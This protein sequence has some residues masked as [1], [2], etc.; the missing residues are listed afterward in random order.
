M[1]QPL[2]VTNR[3]AEY[4]TLREAVWFANLSSV[5]EHPVPWYCRRL[6]VLAKRGGYRLDGTTGGVE[7][8]GGDDMSYRALERG[9]RFLKTELRTLA[10]EG[11]KLEPLEVVYTN[12]RGRSEIRFDRAPD[13]WI[14][15]TVVWPELVMTTQHAIVPTLQGWVMYA[16]LLAASRRWHTR[17]GEPFVRLC[18][19]CDLLFLIEAKEGRPAATCGRDECTA[20]RS[21]RLAA[22]RQSN[23]RQRR[24]KS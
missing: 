24:R 22:D 10:A 14:R 4:E 8:K 19:E 7:A 20:V 13:V 17:R 21:A 6:N 12:E 5:K 9:Q 23:H 1:E 11:G 15:C 18:P 16:A 3:E 2:S